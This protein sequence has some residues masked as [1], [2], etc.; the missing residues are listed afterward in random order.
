[1]KDTTQ[2]YVTADKNPE[3]VT[4]YV[5][6]KEAGVGFTIAST[7]APTAPVEITWWEIQ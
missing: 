7:A 1:M 2:L 6:N 3:N 5:K 4:I